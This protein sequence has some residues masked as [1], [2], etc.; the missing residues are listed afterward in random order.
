M[1]IERIWPGNAW[2]NFHYLIACSETG[3]A[4]A[5]DPLDWQL[6]AATA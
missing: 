4:M 1:I 2:R 5:V 3:E 6:C